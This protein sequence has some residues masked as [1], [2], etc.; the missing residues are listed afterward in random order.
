MGVGDQ[1]VLVR[2][3]WTPKQVFWN[4]YTVGNPDL[5]WS[6]I[7]SLARKFDDITYARS[8]VAWHSDHG[9]TDV[10]ILKVTPKGI[11]MKGVGA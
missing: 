11:A 9:T 8:W 5:W 2:H 1:F 4:G 7:L 10:M 3:I 6:K